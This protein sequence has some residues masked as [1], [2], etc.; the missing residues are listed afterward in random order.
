MTPAPIPSPPR[1][2]VSDGSTARGNAPGGEAPAR[3][4]PRRRRLLSPMQADGGA[5]ASTDD[6]SA[7]TSDPH[8]RPRGQVNARP[9]EQE[10]G[11]RGSRGTLAAGLVGGDVSLDFVAAGPFTYDHATGL[12]SP[13]AVRLR[14]PEHQQDERRRG[15]PRGRRLRVQRPRHVLRRRSRST[16]APTGAAR[17]SSTCPSATRR[18]ASPARLRRHRERGDQHARR[19]QRGPRRQRD[20][21]PFRTSTSTRRATTRSRAPSRS[22]TSTPGRRRSFASSCIWPARWGGTPTGNILNAIDG[23]PR[24]RRRTR[25]TSDRRPSR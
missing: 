20:R 13:P 6:G 14:Q 7:S 25:S 8:R 5:A 15:V 9:L 18:R 19:R 24:R 21:R 23:R 2:L 17:S 4:R 12:G 1:N 11:A 22:R 3:K 10:H 16:T